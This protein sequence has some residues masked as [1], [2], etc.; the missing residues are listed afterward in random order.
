MRENTDRRIV[1]IPRKESE[2]LQD[3]EEEYDFSADEEIR[4]MPQKWLAVARFYSGKKFGTWTMFNDLCTQWGK[5][6]HERIPAFREFGDN[7]FYVEFDSERLWKKAVW[8][9]PWKYK[10]DA[11]IF[12]AYDGV[13]R[14]SEISIESIAVWIRIYDIPTIKMTVGFM[15]AL[16]RKFGNVVEVGEI[17]K[18]YRRV[19]VEIP[20]EKPLMATVD[21][22]VKGEGNMVFAVRYE[23]VPHFCFTCGRLGHAKDDCPDEVDGA[24]VI[25]PKLLRCSP[26][27]WDAGRTMSISSGEHRAKRV[28]NFSGAQKERMMAAAGSSNTPSRGGHASVNNKGRGR[29]GEEN[30]FG[31]AGNRQHAARAHVQEEVEENLSKGLDNMAVDGGIPDLNAVP[32]AGHGKEKVSGI[33]SYMGS[34]FSSDTNKSM[35]EET[36]LSMLEQLSR[37]RNKVHTATHLHVNQ[38]STHEAVNKAGKGG[39]KEGE[40]PAKRGRFSMTAHGNLT[41]TREES[42]QGQ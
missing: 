2:G 17:Y 10:E 32:T 30:S 25:F 35:K 41:G 15:K 29:E 12:V 23:N 14:L 27:K 16:G 33:D 22:D 39:A 7:M 24:G 36:G 21:I 19:R 8:G 28:L 13:R 9:G 26:Q 42:R 31:S 40:S 37:V 6:E 18:N 34:E 4:S 3:D 1:L 11:V 5:K 38:A 20:L